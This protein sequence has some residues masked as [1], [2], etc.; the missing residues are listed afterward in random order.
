MLIDSVSINI[1]LMGTCWADLIVDALRQ[2]LLAHGDARAPL[3]MHERWAAAAR[4]SIV[5]RSG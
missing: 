2:R 5:P 4:S 1:S 3:C